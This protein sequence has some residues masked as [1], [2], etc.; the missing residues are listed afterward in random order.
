VSPQLPPGTP[1]L[2]SILAE[3][4][5]INS[6]LGV[7]GMAVVFA[8]HH[9]H[10]DQRVAVKL[11]RPELA[12][13]PD[14]VARFVREG[15]AAVKLTGEH[16]VRVFDVAKLD[17]GEAYMVLEHL[18]GEDLGKRIEKTGEPLLITHAVDI[19]LE[20]CAALAEVH[21]IGIVHRDLK[22][23]NIF[24]MR[25]PGNVESVKVLDFGISKVVGGLAGVENLGIT[26]TTTML[27]TPVYMSPEQLASSKDVDARTDIWALGIVMYEIVSGV[28]PFQ[29]ATLAETCA[30]VY[31]Q[32][33]TPLAELRPDVPPAVAEAIM[34]C[35]EKDLAQRYSSV[36]ELAFAI[37]PFGTARSQRALEHVASFAS[38]L[39]PP[40][41]APRPLEPTAATASTHELATH[42]LA[43]NATPAAPKKS[44]SV[45]LVAA[46]TLGAVVGLGVLA[47]VR[48]DARRS[49]AR[50]TASA[51]PAT[52]ATPSVIS[53][54][55]ASS[56]I[57]AAPTDSA[58][59]SESP[60]APPPP[61]TAPHGPSAV[62]RGGTRPTPRPSTAPRASAAP[63]PPAAAA[64]ASSDR[65]N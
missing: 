48:A 6:V 56:R 22:P 41:L 3:R 40:N 15:R 12:R 43:S 46:L 10:L 61:T 36:A 30:W 60:P 37:A 29:R 20:T 47:A 18:D 8:A 34:R 49:V 51:T 33:P 58:F 14:V 52:P 64:S 21:A 32:A 25:T 31:T 2:G 63:A 59:A 50:A 45:R 7:G 16:I 11:L 1:S 5:R 42:E 65:F 38:R 23:A 62:V 28:R 55:S 44:S 39:P 17:T 27:G 19:V 57:D 13:D 4:Y 54:S 26:T 35:L 53:P 24:L 9:I